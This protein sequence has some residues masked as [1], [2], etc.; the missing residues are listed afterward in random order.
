MDFC[1]ILLVDDEK[2]VR[3]GL[4]VIIER[5]G[6]AC[7]EIKECMDGQDALKMISEEDFDVVITDIRMPKIDGV[8]FLK[9]AQKLAKK[10]KFIILSGYED[11]GYAVECMKYG[12]HAYLLKPVKKE[13]LFEALERIELV[14]RKEK[15]AEYRNEKMENLMDLFK[16]NELNLILLNESLSGDEIKNIVNTM[17][18]EVFNQGFHIGV[19]FA[20]D[21][22]NCLS[23][24]NRSSALK[25][26]IDGYI[27]KNCSTVACFLDIDGNIV[28]AGS[29]EEYF[30]RLLA[31]LNQNH[32]DAYAYVLGLSEEGKG[33]FDIRRAYLQAKNALKYRIIKASGEM[34]RFSQVMELKNDYTIPSE[35]LAKLYQLAG[36]T[37]IKEIED[38]LYEIFNKDTICAYRI[39]YLEKLAEEINRHVFQRFLESIRHPQKD[40]LEGY[41]SIKDIYRYFHIKDYLTGLRNY[42]LKITEF[43]TALKET[44]KE[45]REMEAAIR[46]IHT[47][48]NKTLDLTNVSNHVSLNYS[49][50]SYL[51][52][53]YTGM[54]FVDYLRKVRIEKAGE[55][56]AGTDDK[57]S[58]IS[59]EV[60]YEST[61]QFTRAFRMV[62]G[63]SPTEFRNKRV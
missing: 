60:G 15:E 1:R 14:I 8:A 27:Q 53:E 33:L 29:N 22:N 41:E 45:K 52:K 58:R 57:I 56:L 6:I 18:I 30:E 12:A 24:E 23:A 31:F 13:E 61:R 59:S 38:L 11:F 17:G 9:E 42:M 28:I 35:A 2:Y 63:I 55:L 25:A 7:E 3:K 54:N 10:P 19:L 16:T 44:G 32:A 20:W 37:R 36:T 51:F 39:E 62:M 49:Y 50:F 4:K 5:S 43:V 46:Y 40:I 21:K 26:Q 48:Y 47:H 34:I